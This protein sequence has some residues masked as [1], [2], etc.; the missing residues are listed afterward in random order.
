MSE[1][2]YM[3]PVTELPSS[4]PRHHVWQAPLLCPR[5][6]ADE[7]ERQARLRRAGTLW[8]EN[9]DACTA[10]VLFIQDADRDR[11]YVYQRPLERDG[12]GYHV[13][14]PCAPLLDTGPIPGRYTM[15]FDER[16]GDLRKTMPHL[17]DANA[18]FEPSRRGQRT[19]G[20]SVDV[21]PERDPQDRT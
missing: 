10:T 16:L 11:L 17:F 21:R 7:R 4:L 9:Y 3:R 6:L 1:I 2:F 5:D 19:A 14:I 8:L 13:M 18:R 12:S 15:T 20:S